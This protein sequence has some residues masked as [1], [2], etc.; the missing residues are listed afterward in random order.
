VYFNWYCFWAKIRVGFFIF[1][2]TPRSFSSAF[3]C[4]NCCR[5]KLINPAPQSPHS[6]YGQHR[7][8]AFSG[9]VNSPHKIVSAAIF[10]FI[11]KDAYL[12]PT[13]T[14]T[15]INEEIT[16]DTARVS[17]QVRSALSILLFGVLLIGSLFVVAEP[18][19]SCLTYRLLSLY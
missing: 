3:F 1:H 15:A 4:S 6:P 19:T 8:C 10:D 13:F 2:R 17:D 16:M 18:V 14:H 7:S 5:S 11:E 9:F 12:Y